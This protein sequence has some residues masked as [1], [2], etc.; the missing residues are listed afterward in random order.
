MTNNYQHS[1][2]VNEALESYGARTHGNLARR[3]ERLKR[4]TELKNRAYAEEL[5]VDRLREMMC[6][7]TGKT[8][9]QSVMRNLADQFDEVEI[10]MIDEPRYNLR[11]QRNSANGMNLLLRAIENGFVDVNR[12]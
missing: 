7:G 1:I 11:S 3:V 9:R 6:H 8:G 10:P 4:F 12:G 2:K 5:R